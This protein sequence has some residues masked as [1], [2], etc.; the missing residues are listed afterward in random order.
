M[1]ELELA[2]IAVAELYANGAEGEAHTVYSFGGTKTTNAISRNTHRQLEPATS[3][4]STSAAGSTATRPR[5]GV[6]SAWGG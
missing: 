3:S 6:P 4:R 2:G 5:W 1:T